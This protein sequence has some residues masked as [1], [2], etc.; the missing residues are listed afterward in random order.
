MTAYALS[1]A[2]GGRI[3][4]SGAYRLCRLRGEMKMLD[5]EILEALCDVLAVEPGELLER[6]PK[7]RSRPATRKVR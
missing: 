3:S 4:M 2:S 7:R 1:V 5:T 6:E